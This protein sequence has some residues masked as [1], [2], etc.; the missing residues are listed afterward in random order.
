MLAPL[1]GAVL[2]A[3]ES[4]DFVIPWAPTLCPGM[5]GVA[6]TS[7]GAEKGWT[8]SLNRPAVAGQGVTALNWGV[9]VRWT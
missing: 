9:G 4:G 8:G 1:P 3:A 2:G 6:G 5:R 7:R